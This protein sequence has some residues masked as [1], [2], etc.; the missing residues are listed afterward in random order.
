[1]RIRLVREVSIYCEIKR[2]IV[3]GHRDKITKIWLIKTLCVYECMYVRV[4]MWAH[5]VGG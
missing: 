1:M 2:V 5:A 4:C 3:V